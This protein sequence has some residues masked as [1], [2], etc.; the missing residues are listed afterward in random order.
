MVMI[1]AMAA[2][3]MPVGLAG[4]WQ[5]LCVALVP[6]GLLCAPALSTTM[7]TLSR[8]V[9]AAARG[10]AMGLHGTALTLGLAVSSPITG[11]IIDAYGTRWSFAI[12]G[13]GGI[14]F[15][16]LSIPLWR[17]A[18]QPAEPAVPEPVAA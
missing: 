11:S 4:S 10:E 6:A 5:L 8:W 9:P 3:T 2:L 18:P 12:A 14:L 13:L 15:V 17:R 7:D 16:T 1:G